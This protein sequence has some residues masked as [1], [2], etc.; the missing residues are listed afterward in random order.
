[1]IPP[2]ALIQTPDEVK[3]AQQEAEKIVKEEEEAE[4]K[5]LEKDGNA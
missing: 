2:P 5:E 1:M 3:L 4:A